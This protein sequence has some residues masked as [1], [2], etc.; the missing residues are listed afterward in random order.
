MRSRIS[1][2]YE[3]RGFSLFELMIALAVV[4]VLSAVAIPAYQSYIDT[5]SMTRVT[6]NF[7][8]AIRVAQAEFTKTKSRAALGI[9]HPVPASTQA[10]VELLNSDGVRAPGGGPAYIASKNNKAFR[11]DAETGAIGVQWQKKKARLRLWRPL[12]LSLVEQRADIT[13]NSI[14]VKNQRSP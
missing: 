1:K 5:A 9:N 13:S 11:G 4:G 10:W 7:E 6:A 8:Q 14:E 2:H 3:V 12:Y